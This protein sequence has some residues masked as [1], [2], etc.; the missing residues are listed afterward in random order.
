MRPLLLL[1]ALTPASP[2][3]PLARPGRAAARPLPAAGAGQE[4][5][6]ALAGQVSNLHKR[7]DHAGVLRLLKQVEAQAATDASALTPSLVEH[8]LLSC[9]QKREWNR[10]LRLFE[11]SRA[12]GNLS[13]T[14][15]AWRAA[16]R[17]CEKGRQWRAALR[18]LDDHAADAAAAGGDRDGF[19]PAIAS[20]AILAC[21]RGGQLDRA[22]ALLRETEGR[23]SARVRASA[24]TAG[25][26]GAAAP[27]PP[28]PL[29]LSTY[30]GVISACADRGRWQQALAVLDQ[31]R[32]ALHEPDVFSYTSA[33]SACG[34]AGEAQRALSLLE[35]MRERGVEPDTITYTCAIAACAKASSAR[36]GDRRDRRGPRASR[37]AGARASA[38][39]PRVTWSARALELL[40]EVCVGLGRATRSAR[41]YFSLAR[42]CGSPG[43]ARTSGRTPRPSR[44]AAKPASGRGR[45][46]CSSTCAPWES[47]SPRRIFDSLQSPRARARACDF[48]NPV[49]R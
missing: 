5:T 2:F 32:K 6:L 20:S 38:K 28:K 33:I 37:E 14:P 36:K 3:V 1:F 43:C 19:D 16:A 39:A 44:R 12:A 42:R 34:R 41:S 48:A 4:A 24:R 35:L 40:D 11:R 15:R 49:D 8:G 22:L 23:A 17:A 25:G 21:A 47:P 13:I 45:S 7:G 29:P 9:C 31:A 30:N 46:N 18:L 26:A 27:K 10:A